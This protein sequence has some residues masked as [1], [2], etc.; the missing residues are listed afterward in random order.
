ML[1]FN[2]LAA[3]GA[4]PAPGRADRGARRRQPRGPLGLQRRGAGPRRRRIRHPGHLGGRPRD[5]LDADRF[6]RR[7]ARADADRRGRN[8]GAGQGRAGGRPRQPAT[9]GCKACIDARHRPQAAGA[10]RR[11]P[12]AALARPVAGAAAPPLRRG[13]QPAR[14]GADGGD[15]PQARALPGGAADAGDAV[16]AHR[17]SRPAKRAR[18]RPRADGAA[19]HPARAPRPLRTR[20]GAADAGGDR[21]PAGGLSRNSSP[22]CRGAATTRP[23]AASNGCAR[24]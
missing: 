23:T 6:R 1:G 16:A 11:R 21:A 14:P 5:R 22:H 2:A 15:R 4:D 3:G 12:R 9:R 7:H 19:R 8:G 10:A 18:P 24:G 13:D 20:C 17:R